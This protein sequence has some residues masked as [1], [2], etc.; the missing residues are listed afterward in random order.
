MIEA[1]RQSSAVPITARDYLVS[2]TATENEVINDGEFE[3]TI[4]G[5]ASTSAPPEIHAAA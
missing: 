2:R 5:K 4:Y 1:I 3:G